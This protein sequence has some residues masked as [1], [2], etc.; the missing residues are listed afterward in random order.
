MKNYSYSLLY[1]SLL[2]AVMIVQMITRYQLTQLKESGYGHRVK[3]EQMLT[4]CMNS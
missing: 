3:I 1:S 2:L 4:Q